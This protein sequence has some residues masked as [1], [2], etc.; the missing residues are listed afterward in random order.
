MSLK[1]FVNRVFRGFEDIE[2]NFSEQETYKVIDVK[3]LKENR[4]LLNIERID[5]KSNKRQSDILSFAENEIPEDIG[6]GDVLCLTE[7]EGFV[8]FET[9]IVF[10]G[11]LGERFKYIKSERVTWLSEGADALVRHYTLDFNETWYV[12]GKYYKGVGQCLYAKGDEN[13]SLTVVNHGPFKQG[14][15]VVGSYDKGFKGALRKETLISKFGLKKRILK[16]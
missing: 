1:C 4:V 11:N 2:T 8:D 3:S 15:L 7:V 9:G 5:P 16:P 12:A 14:G 10:D 13:N 6:K